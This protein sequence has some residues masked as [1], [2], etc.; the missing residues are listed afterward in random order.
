MH[1]VDARKRAP[2]VVLL[3]RGAVRI[4]AQMRL[5][6]TLS[7]A[8]AALVLVGLRQAQAAVRPAAVASEQF[9][10]VQRQIHLIEQHLFVPD[11]REFGGEQVLLGLVGVLQVDERNC[12]RKEKS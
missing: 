4:G 1:P 2:N 3:L 9:A 10:L 5:M 11:Q 7:I 12:I 8:P 6:F